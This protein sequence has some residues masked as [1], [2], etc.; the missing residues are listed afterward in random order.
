MPLPAFRSAISF[1]ISASGG[2]QV[3]GASAGSLRNL[4]AV[5][6]PPCRSASMRIHAPDRRADLLVKRL[7]IQ[8]LAESAFAGSNRASIFCPSAAMPFR[9]L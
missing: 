1:L 2:L 5:P 6:C 8:Q 7:V 4:P 9:R 3:V